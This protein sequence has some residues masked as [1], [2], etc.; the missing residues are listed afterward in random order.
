MVLLEAPKDTLVD[1]IC[2]ATPDRFD[3][4]WSSCLI[5]A[6]MYFYL[7][8]SLRLQSC[9][10]LR[11]YIAVFMSSI[12]THGICKIHDTYCTWRA[13]NLSKLRGHM[14]NHSCPDS[15]CFALR[16]RAIQ[17]SSRS[18]MVISSHVLYYHSLVIHKKEGFFGVCNVRICQG[19][20]SNSCCLSWCFLKKSTRIWSTCWIA[21]SQSDNVNP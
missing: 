1:C 19:I 17:S 20:A 13:R 4:V 6:S 2:K 14:V 3:K 8:Q 15:D 18:E 16:P 7:L 9:Y 11:L 5:C 10:V 12:T 21:V